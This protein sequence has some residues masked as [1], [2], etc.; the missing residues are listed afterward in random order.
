M[1]PRKTIRALAAC[2]TAVIMAAC[3]GSNSSA[4]TATATT[5]TTSYSTTTGT[6]T[7]TTT[8][9]GTA[10]GTSAGTSTATTTAT[11][12]STSTGTATDTVTIFVNT[13][14]EISV[15]VTVTTT[16]TGTSSSL[17]GS[18]N[19]PATSYCIDYD[20]SLSGTAG[21]FTF[22][23]TS[24]Y[25]YYSLSGATSGR[26]T[27][28]HSNGTYTWGVSSATITPSTTTA[29]QQSSCVSQGGL[30]SPEPFCSP[31]MSD[32]HCTFVDYGSGGYQTIT[33][34]RAATWFVP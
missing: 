10:T 24:H 8:N 2:S 33:F 12:T 32:G 21:N 1:Y 31:D 3:G 16:G 4:K 18:C 15:A 27:C 30:Y 14:V 34:T 22:S 20:Y 28:N 17:K 26:T 23:A 6:N 19:F 13:S 29:T 11:T 25:Y 7:S 9:T 5:T